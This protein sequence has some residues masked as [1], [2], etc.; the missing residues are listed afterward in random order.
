MI[1]EYLEYIQEAKYTV[2]PKEVLYHATLKQGLKQITPSS[3]NIFNNNVVWGSW[4]RPYAAM[5]A[6]PMRVTGYAGVSCNDSK[7]N[8][9]EY[10][11]AEITSKN[12]QFLRKP[13]SLYSIR[14][15]DSVWERPTK[16]IKGV[17]ASALPGAATSGICEVVKEEKYKTVLDC[18]QKN[19]VGIMFMDS[20]KIFPQKLSSLAKLSKKTIRL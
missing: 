9:C 11:V 5:F 18:L 14:P 3:D 4:Y 19:K 6:M 2:K 1:K 10:W 16:D 17:R 20:G 15:I 12:K 8:Q 13:C 7:P